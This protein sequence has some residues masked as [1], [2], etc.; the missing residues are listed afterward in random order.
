MTREEVK[1]L[2][3]RAVVPL[4]QAELERIGE[5]VFPRVIR[6]IAFPPVEVTWPEVQEAEALVAVPELP[7]PSHE[8]W[9]PAPRGLIPWETELVTG[10]ASTWSNRPAAAPTPTF[11]VAAVNKIAAELR[12]ELAGR[13]ADLE[14]GLWQD[15]LLHGRIFNPP[16]TLWGYPVV[17][18]ADEAWS[19]PYPYVC[20]W[21]SFLSDYRE[22]LALQQ[23]YMA[24]RRVPRVDPA[25]G[26]EACALEPTVSQSLQFYAWNCM[27]VGREDMAGMSDPYLPDC[28]PY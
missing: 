21:P 26:P 9:T 17:T 27:L 12:A 11:D 6:A 7:L 15:T 24:W 23:E 18:A 10:E 20:P 5:R 4:A 28:D 22:A 13:L 25:A 19:R 2:M 16:A 1:A 8:L 14:R 3:Q